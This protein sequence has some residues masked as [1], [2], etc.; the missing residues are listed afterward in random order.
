MTHVS[1]SAPAH[2][3]CRPAPS[4]LQ[5][6]CEQAADGEDVQYLQKQKQAH[7]EVAP[8]AGSL[9]CQA[10]KSLITFIRTGVL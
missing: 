6:C 10:L 8:A 1:L 4:Y 9:F 2:R 7:G 3:P 5:G